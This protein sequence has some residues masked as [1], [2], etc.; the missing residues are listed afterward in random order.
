MSDLLVIIGED[1][2]LTLDLSNANLLTTG[3]DAPITVASLI[4]QTIVADLANTNALTAGIDDPAL[5]LTGTES[6]QSVID[7][8]D[9]G[10]SVGLD[11]ICPPIISTPPTGGGDDDI[12]QAIAGQSLSGHRAV[13]ISGGQAFYADYEQLTA[14]LT[15][16][17]TLQAAAA[18]DAVSILTEGEIDEVSWSW[19]PGQTIFLGS[20]GLLTQTPPAA[21]NVVEIGLA[22]TP[23]RL[24]VRIQPAILL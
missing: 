24:F 20:N 21:G 11:P 12:T 5:L 1:L 22:L 15:V 2:G 8:A 4:E 16:G 17:I 14:A 3:S 13:Y 10:L 23:Q 19:T 18:G 6:S 9:P 7:N